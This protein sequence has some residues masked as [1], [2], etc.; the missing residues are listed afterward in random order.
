[1]K[2]QIRTKNYSALDL[3]SKNKGIGDFPVRS[4]IRLGSRTSTKDCF[5]RSYGKK[6]IIEVNTVEAVENSRDK[7][8]MKDCF[9]EVEVPQT[10]W[11]KCQEDNNGYT[12]YDT[13]KK[14]LRSSELP[15]PILAKR[16]CGFKGRG[17][18][19]LD[20]Q[21]QLEDFLQNTN[22]TPYYF[23]RYYSGSAEY[24]LHITEED[25]FMA[26]RKLRKDDTPEDKRWYFN[27]D[28]C[29]WVNE[30]HE[31]FNKPSNWE[32]MVAQ[33]INAL[34]AV[35]LD[36]GSVDLRCQSP[37]KR[38]PKFIIVE[39][40]SAPSL[41]KIGIEKYREQLKT[42]IINKINKNG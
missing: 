15:Y 25:C 16:I 14:S 5:P 24:R 20:N 35:G 39:I 27:S 11:W 34:K 37:K 22:L 19:K 28:H 42:I 36:I 10:D 30:E 6:P 31:S 4:V 38:N 41:G 1:M 17:M 3:R 40:N 12:F 7:L 9:N 23:E 33:S 18:F 29:N 2:P 8:K 26:W 21:E 32:E 13:G